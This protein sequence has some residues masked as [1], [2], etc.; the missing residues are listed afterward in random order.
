M[1][2]P[3]VAMSGVNSRAKWRSLVVSMLLGVGP[4]KLRARAA[5]VGE[6]SDDSAFGESG[7]VEDFLELS[8]GFG[9]VIRLKISQAATVG[10]IQDEVR[11]ERAQVILFDG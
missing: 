5:M 2:M 10:A 3:S 4:S 7:M 9:R 6:R 1:W 8:L 11:A